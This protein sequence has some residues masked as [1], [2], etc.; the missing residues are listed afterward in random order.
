MSPVVL[1]IGFWFSLVAA[2]SAFLIDYQEQLSH[3]EGKRTP[4]QLALVTGLIAFLVF[5]A[6]TLCLAWALPIAAR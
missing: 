6:L 2:V 4:L 5:A 3:Y 1:Y